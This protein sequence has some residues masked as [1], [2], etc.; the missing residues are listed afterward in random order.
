MHNCAK[1]K[2][3][4]I[5]ILSHFPHLSFVIERVKDGQINLGIFMI[6]K[7]KAHT[8]YISLILFDRCI[9]ILYSLQE[10]NSI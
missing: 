2:D 9:G 1:L 6:M 7:F 5:G 4:K 8:K 3:K 10:V